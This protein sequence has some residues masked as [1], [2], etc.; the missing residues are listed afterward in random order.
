MLHQ[1]SRNELAIGK[2][3]LDLLKNATVAVLGIG[4]V[5]SFAAEA[6]VRSGVG[7]LVLVDKD[8]V[9]I[10]NVNRQIHALL[11]TVGQQKVELMRDRVKEINPDCEVIALK[12]FYTEETYEQFFSYGLDYVIDAS[13]TVMYKIHIMKEC[14]A[15]NIKMIS[16]MGAANK[17]DPTRFQ[18]ADISKTH[19]DPLAKVIRTKLRKEGITKGIPVVF[20]DESP[21]VI[22]EDVRKIVGNDEAKIR[23]AQM[24]PSSN[25]FVPS[26]AG[27]IAASWVVRDIVKDIEIRRVSDGNY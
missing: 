15:R 4:G 17:M 26:V 8:D 11:S 27:L 19:T 12:M 23:K 1:F 25:A 5:G 18:I 13:D 3:G 14:L 9:D 22:R 24:P 21:I 6:L 7:R 20:S 10:T 2:E 16:S